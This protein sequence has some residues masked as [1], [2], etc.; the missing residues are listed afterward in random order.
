MLALLGPLALAGSPGSLSAQ[1]S[2]ADPVLPRGQLWVQVDGS[3]VS[4][5]ELF[6]AGDE[7]T[8]LGA[9]F[10]D[11]DIGPAEVPALADLQTRLQ[12]IAGGT[13][14]A[15]L[16]V[17]GTT[18][19]FSAE[20]QAAVVGLS[21]GLLGRLTVGASVPFVRRRVSALLRHTPEGANVGPS[22]ILTMPAEVATFLTESAMALGSLQD[23]VN[24]RCTAL[25][26]THAECVSGRSLVTETDSF[27]DAVD[28]AYDDAILFPLAGSDLGTAIGT[29]WTAIRTGMATWMADAPEVVPLAEDPLDHAAFRS[30]VLDP[31]WPVEGFPLDNT[32]T[33]LAIGDVELNAA[34][35]LFRADSAAVDGE[36]LGI[37]ATVLGSVRFPTGQPDS[38]RAIAP[39]SPPRGVS[40]FSLGLATDLLLSS[41][42]ALLA[43]VQAT[44]NGTAETTLVAPD[45]TRL[46]QPGFDRTRV[47]WEPGDQ[48]S[49]GLSPRF[50]FG[51]P[52]SIGAG[53][54]YVRQEADRFVALDQD[55]A[56][57]P[58][59]AG[60]FTFQRLHVELRYSATAGALAE[61]VRLP[62]EAY[63][64][65]SRAVSGSGEWAPVEKR[66]E[67]GARFLLRR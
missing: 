67:A 15:G 19:R 7:R 26:E 12:A 63:I 21:Y 24:V 46:F 60:P 11:L 6:G 30:L 64:R 50:H 8:P 49:F 23:S 22:P 28:S 57:L 53:W 29:R 65:G 54:T 51:L 31:A 40:G 48:L 37:R 61:S 56:D 2:A 27:L 1:Q 58:E 32:P 62:F 36:G 34:F 42:L 17:G 4:V 13:T 20:E 5:D 9:P 55:D 47:E 35:A 66:L 52:L 38:L 3:S 10:F 39:L 45:P 14:P 25:G 59:P 43:Q 18:G 16:R 33:F 41:R 44:W